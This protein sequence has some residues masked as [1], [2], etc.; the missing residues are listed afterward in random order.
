MSKLGLSYAYL[1]NP[2]LKE[3]SERVFEGVEAGRT[4]ALYNWFND[5]WTSMDLTIG[6]FTS[7]QDMIIEDRK[8]DINKVL[9]GHK[10]KFLD[11]SETFLV[12]GSYEVLGSSYKPF[13]GRTLAG[14]Y[15][16]AFTKKEKYMYGPYID[17]DTLEVGDCVSVFFDEVTLMFI[18]PFYI[19]GQ[20][21]YFCG[22][23]PND[24]MSD[25]QQDE[26]SH[27]YKDSGDNYLFM[28]ENKRN[29]A[30]GTAISR[31][32][33][34][35]NTFTLG[36]NLKEGIRTKDFG[37]V[38]IA[39]HTE[40]EIV[41]N[42]PKTQKLHEGVQKTIDNGSNIEAWPGYPE[43]RHILVG[44][45]GIL[46]NPPHTDEQWG[47]LCEGDIDEIFNYRRIGF[48]TF[49]IEGTLM[50]G[51]L[52]VDTYLEANYPSMLIQISIVTWFIVMILFLFLSRMLT[53]GPLEKATGLLK[54]IAE[55]E[56]DLTKRIPVSSNDEM[57]ELARWFNKFVNNQMNIVKRIFCATKNTNQ[58]VEQMG[59]IIVHLCSSREDMEVAINEILSTMT[60]YTSELKTMN[61]KFTTISEAIGQIYVTVHKT[62]EQMEVTNDQATV[63]HKES[64]VASQAM[65]AIVE[66]IQQAYN[67]MDELESHSSQVSTVIE[68]INS[69][70]DQTKLLALNASIE[71]A[72]AGEH[73]LGFSVVAD[74]ISKLADMT[75]KS[76]VKIDQIIGNIEEGVINSKTHMTNMNSNVLVGSKKVQH[77]IESF[78]QIQQA[79]A[80]MSK[81][82]DEIANEMSQR[83]KDMDEVQAIVNDAVESFEVVA[84]NN[85]S[86]SQQVLKEFSGHVKSMDS[87]KESMNYT[88]NYLYELVNAFKL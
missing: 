36:E 39:K 60:V 81:D 32:R 10:E 79:I 33:F 31:S 8:E 67:G 50:A 53:I 64:E 11:Y 87:I 21:Y 86:R 55:G 44:G 56:G 70:S 47:L 35:D 40:F 69:I 75:S 45:K 83:T 66:N 76:T 54:E 18:N 80:N 30:K 26:D 7:H 34:E 38:K 77:S 74:E 85:E 6:I 82:F 16:E 48:K 41:F 59:G 51:L 19:E 88:A 24:V 17:M 62:K 23:I 29:I 37:T 42:N 14:E 65:E 61:S 52:A 5:N 2:G 71:A 28:V 13:V 20:I 27:I 3:H 57:G 46:I 4:K 1:V 63:S 12:N 84:K 72:R 73:G 25:V 68:V 15:V 22:R 49:L 78:E 9:L 58:S 43:Y